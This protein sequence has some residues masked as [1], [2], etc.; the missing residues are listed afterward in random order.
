MPTLIPAEVGPL[1]ERIR[2]VLEAVGVVATVATVAIALFLQWWLVRRRRPVLGLDLSQKPIDEDLA[3]L[4]FEDRMEFWLRVKVLASPKKD[5]AHNVEVLL[6][7]VTRPPHAESPG[8]VPTRQLAWADTPTE[9]PAIPA[10]TWRRVDV[11]K[12]VAP[13]NTADPLTLVPALKEYD[14][15]RASSRSRRYSGERYH[16]ND[17]GNYEF[18]LALTADEAESSW[19]RLTFSYTSPGEIVRTGPQ[20]TASLQLV[21]RITNIVLGA[22]ENTFDM[23]R[24]RRITR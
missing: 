12:L 22:H 4:D 16:L 23:N 21:P 11:L 19:W 14:E 24:L 15:D 2:T 3:P 7:K 18:V 9:R 20:A 8:L 17:E 6:L 10:G 5:T 1:E 13:R